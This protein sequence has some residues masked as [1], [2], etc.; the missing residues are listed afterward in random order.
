[1]KW[2]CINPKPRG[3]RTNHTTNMLKRERTTL[4]QQA[5]PIYNSVEQLQPLFCL[6]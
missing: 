2:R 4:R 6:A 3:E 5:A 1:M